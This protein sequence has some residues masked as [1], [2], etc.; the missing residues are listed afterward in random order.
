MPANRQ[1]VIDKV[2]AYVARV[3][4]DTSIEPPGVPTVMVGGGVGIA[5]LDEMDGDDDQDEP[6]FPRPA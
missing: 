1:E 6:G 5:A 4:G 3:Y 2:S